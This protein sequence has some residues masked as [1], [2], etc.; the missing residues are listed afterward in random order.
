MEGEKEPGLICRRQTLEKRQVQDDSHVFASALGR[1][2]LCEKGGGYLHS[3]SDLRKREKRIINP[4]PKEGGRT[5]FVPALRDKSAN[6]W[7]SGDSLKRTLRKSVRD[8]LHSEGSKEI[9]KRGVWTLKIRRE[10]GK[11]KK[12]RTI[13]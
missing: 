2:Q 5:R 11:E 1:G 10:G 12:E 6:H 9:E 13:L 8:P 4:A 3:E 7:H